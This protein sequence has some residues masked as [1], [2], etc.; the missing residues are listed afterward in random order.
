MSTETYYEVRVDGDVWWRGTRRSA[1]EL[2]KQGAGRIVRVTT[3]REPVG[4]RWVGDYL[5]DG[6]S[7]VSWAHRGISGAWTV[8]DDRVKCPREIVALTEDEARAAAEA[9]VRATWGDA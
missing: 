2:A 5:Y 7:V 1:E 6:D 4:L 9:A 8:W 3:T